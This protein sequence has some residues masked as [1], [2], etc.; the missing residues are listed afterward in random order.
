V[1]QHSYVPWMWQGS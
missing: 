1:K